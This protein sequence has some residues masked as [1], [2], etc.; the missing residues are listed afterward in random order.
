MCLSSRESMARSTISVGE[1][2]KSICTR[3]KHNVHVHVTVYFHACMYN[4]MHVYMYMYIHIHALPL[5]TR[6]SSVSIIMW[7][8]VVALFST[9][10][11]YC[12][13]FIG[14]FCHV[15]VHIRRMVCCCWC[16]DS[17]K[18]TTSTMNTCS[19]YSTH[20]NT[21]YVDTLRNITVN[22]QMDCTQ[23]LIYYVHLHIEWGFSEQYNIIIAYM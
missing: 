18:R 14:Q 12:T 5:S 20:E 2:P 10:T 17:S 19:V 4:V 23:V 9:C 13:R 7:K 16:Y 15:H 11:L 1:L 21:V 22:F 3:I 6:C 8:L